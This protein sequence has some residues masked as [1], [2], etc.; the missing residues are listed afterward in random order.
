MPLAPNARRPPC[1]SGTST[2][3]R[4]WI[5]EP[6]LAASGKGVSSRARAPSLL[7]A[8]GASI[9]AASNTATRGAAVVASGRSPTIDDVAL[10]ESA[11]QIDEVGRIVLRAEAAAYHSTWFSTHA[12][13]YA[14]RIRELVD[15]GMKVSAVDF[16]RADQARLRFREDMA[17]IFER[18][19]ALLMPAAP[20]TA[21]PLSLG[22]TGDPV[23]CA[24]WSFGGFPAIAIPSG[25]SA[26]RLPFGIQ[27]VAGTHGEQ[28]LLEVAE[29]CEDLLKFT[30]EPKL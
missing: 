28:R 25:L 8:P 13:Q 20:A 12:A 3:Q 19:D 16:V 4:S 2:A 27:L 10:P 1:P 7:E 6:G 15:T 26:A 30:A 17:P 22:T 24:P 29:W 11:D 18:Y 14:P 9:S 5:V 23:L 21:P